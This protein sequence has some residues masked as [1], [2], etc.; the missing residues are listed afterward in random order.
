MK[1]EKNIVSEE[2]KTKL[3]ITFIYV[4]DEHEYNQNKR[5]S[6]LYIKSYT[7]LRVYL[8]FFEVFFVEKSR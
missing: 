7:K 6:S 2:K 5:S 3:V 4:Y 8:I 1:E